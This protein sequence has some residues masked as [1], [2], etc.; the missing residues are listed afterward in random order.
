MAWIAAVVGAGISAYGSKSAA[1]SAEA[2][3]ARYQGQLNADRGAGIAYIDEFL[4]QL[5]H[6][7]AKT[8]QLYRERLRLTQGSAVAEQALIAEQGDAA[9][10]Q[11][12]EREESRMGEMRGSMARRGLSS[13]TVQDS[14]AR[15][16]GADTDRQLLGLSDQLANQRAESLRSNTLMQGQALSDLGGVF[17]SK[18]AARG[19]YNSQLLQLLSGTQVTY[20]PSLYGLEANAWGQL[21]GAI[22]GANWGGSGGGDKKE[23]KPGGFSGG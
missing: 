23:T 6:D 18:T 13:S 14:Y 2:G 3:A 15:G 12:L 11:I 10:R 9:R 17:Q 16:I 19:Q 1:D 8:E 22:A 4:A 5:E 20:D 7:Y 21:G